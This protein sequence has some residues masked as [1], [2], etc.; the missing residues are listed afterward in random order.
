MI[1]DPDWQQF[2]EIEAQVHF[3]S[4]GEHRLRVIEV[5]AGEPVLLVH[6]F[7]D[8]A[9]TWQRNLRAL[10]KA[11]FR[12]VAYDHPGCGES[13]L[14]AGFRFGVDALAELAVGVLDALGVE[15]AHVIGHSMGGG[16]GLHLAVHHPRRLR[17]VV[18]VAPTCYHAPFRPFV[19]LFRWGLFNA[20]SRRLAGPWLA[21]PVLIS[22]Y[23][24]TTLLTPPV[25]AQYRLAFRRPEYLPA[26]TGLLRDYWNAAFTATA[27]HYREITVP[28]HLIWGDRDIWVATGHYAPRLA[29]DTGDGL[30]IVPRAGHL[31]HQAQPE[32]F[33]ETAV[34]FLKGESLGQSFFYKGHEGKGRKQRAGSRQSESGGHNRNAQ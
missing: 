16:I 24:D 11:G 15:Q 31:V 14:P 20:A 5:G 17:R 29:A 19:F 12:A 25:L 2:L 1:G 8:S 33:N 21:K 30:T 10:T 27:R 18:L 4:I 23:W 13:A 32:R 26:C 6:G 9:Y 3:V 7:A 34:C 22:Q 28:L